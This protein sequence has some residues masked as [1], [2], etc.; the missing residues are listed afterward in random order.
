MPGRSGPPTFDKPGSR[1]SDTERGDERA[2][3][4]AGA[5]MDDHSGGLIHDG[6]ILVFV[7][8]IASGIFSGSTPGSG[9]AGISTVMVWPDSM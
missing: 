2:G 5:G 6:N 8:N 1:R 7:K 9:G 3:I 4:R